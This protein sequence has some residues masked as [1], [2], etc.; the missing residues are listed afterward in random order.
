MAS[1]HSKTLILL[2]GWAG[3]G[4]DAAAAA[5]APLGF[6][7]FAFADPLKEDV[8]AA[9][10]LP[11]A[12]FER[13]FKDQPL[14]VSDSRTP[15]DLLLAHAAT[16]RATDPDIYARAITNAI[17]NNRVTR[18]VI[19]DW[20]YRREGA[21]VQSH[22]PTDWQV[23]RIRI[24]RPGVIPSTAA[25]EHELDDFPMDL[26]V[27]NDGTLADLSQKLTDWVRPRL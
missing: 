25:I 27:K 4:K 11:P 7:R 3:S 8:A 23:F 16:A 20:R 9:T 5:L 19:S 14:S 17:L 12:M 2:S 22:L 18:A 6:Q 15:R 26:D 13:P 10:G 24:E 21:F 1:S